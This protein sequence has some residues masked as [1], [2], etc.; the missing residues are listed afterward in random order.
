MWQRLILIDNRKLGFAPLSETIVKLCHRRHGIGAD[1]IIF[2]ETSSTAHFRMRI[3][4]ADGSEAEMCGNG[5]RCLA[6]YIFSKE[7]IL[8]TFT[9]QTMHD[10]MEVSVEGPL[11]SVKMPTPKENVRLHEVSVGLQKFQLHVLDTGVPHAVLFVDNIEQDG[12]LSAAPQIRFH[13]DFHPRGTNINFAKVCSDNTIAVRTYERGVEQETLAC[14]TGAVAT[15][16]AA[17]A[18]YGIKTPIAIRVRSGDYLHINFEKSLKNLTMT[19]PAVKIYDGI[20]FQLQG[21]PT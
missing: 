12:L 10:Q 8:P 17:A 20:T 18:A 9:I 11:V 4:N 1:G 16:I 15:A 21:S 13:S 5:V 2:L 19:G 3:F 6:H 14:G 7:D